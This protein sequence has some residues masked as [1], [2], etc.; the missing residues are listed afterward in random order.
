MPVEKFEAGV[1]ASA[2][3]S[4][5]IAPGSYTFTFDYA[6]MTLTV[7]GESGLT[8]LSTEDNT[9]A[10][11]FNLQGVRVLNPERGIFIRVNNGKATRVAM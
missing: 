10:V 4:W 5:A 9:N 1:D 2:A 6:A 11:Y 7:T 8:V 3:Y